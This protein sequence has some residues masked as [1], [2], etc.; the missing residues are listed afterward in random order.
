MGENPREMC[1]RKQMHEPWLETCKTMAF[2]AII[3]F[4]YKKLTSRDKTLFQ[5][6]EKNYFTKCQRY[7]NWSLI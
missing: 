6:L 4:Y 2:K 3:T 7:I 5:L 1:M